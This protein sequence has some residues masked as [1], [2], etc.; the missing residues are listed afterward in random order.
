MQ[1]EDGRSGEQNG[2]GNQPGDV[3]HD[4]CGYTKS[5]LDENQEALQELENRIANL[6]QELAELQRVARGR[7]ELIRLLKKLQLEANAPPEQSPP[8]VKRTQRDRV[9]GSSG[10]AHAPPV[11]TLRTL[12]G[13]AETADQVVRILQTTGGPMH[14]RAIYEA[15][16]SA[17]YLIIG[18]DPANSLLSRVA[19]D[20]RIVRDLCGRGF[21]TLSETATHTSQP[22]YVAEVT[23]TD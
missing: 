19:G 14:Y 10:K 4:F 6:Q 9:E 3:A 5:H 1:G 17:G 15:L 8:Q 13:R 20:S 11:A 16:T 18:K 22:E 23:L 2:A 21:Y 12:R 7:Q